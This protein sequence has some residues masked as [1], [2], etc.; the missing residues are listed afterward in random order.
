MVISAWVEIP[1]I[2][3]KPTARGKFKESDCQL[4][5]RLKHNTQTGKLYLNELVS[6]FAHNRIAYVTPEIVEDK[7]VLDE[8]ILNESIR[9]R[10]FD[11]KIVHYIYDDKVDISMNNDVRMRTKKKFGLLNKNSSGKE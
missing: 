3:V 8:D 4:K 1:K 11:K 5:T 6:L 7:E 9:Y 10:D 2:C